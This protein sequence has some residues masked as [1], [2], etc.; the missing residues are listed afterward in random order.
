MPST[1]LFRRCGL[2]LTKPYR[3]VGKT[4]KGVG[5][6]YSHLY[7]SVALWFF[8]SYTLSYMEE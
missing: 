6:R 2:S 5:T 8:I 4:N 7:F 1:K 3:A